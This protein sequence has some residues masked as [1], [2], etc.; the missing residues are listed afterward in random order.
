M[1]FGG[2]P[3]R[4][5]PDRAE[6]ARRKRINRN[7]TVHYEQDEVDLQILLVTK[8]T[9]P[10]RK[11]SKAELTKILNDRANDVFERDVELGSSQ[12]W[13]QHEIHET[14][15]NFYRRR[16]ES[17]QRQA[18]ERKSIQDCLVLIDEIVDEMYAHFGSDSEGEQ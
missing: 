13:K 18:A 11:V 3:P 15:Q 14:M 7:F 1:S 8:A 17:Q 10:A 16:K 2:P 4:R 9:H 5:N 12:P 6:V